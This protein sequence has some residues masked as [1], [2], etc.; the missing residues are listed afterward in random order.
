MGFLNCVSV[1]LVVFV[2]FKDLAIGIRRFWYDH[3]STSLYTCCK[4]VSIGEGKENSKIRGWDWCMQ[5]N[6]G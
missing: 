4:H 6:L 1:F 5:S 2:F 3:V